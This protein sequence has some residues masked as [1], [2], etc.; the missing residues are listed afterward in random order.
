M[1]LFPITGSAALAETA[2]PADAGADAPTAML[3]LASMMLQIRMP[4]PPVA[5]LTPIT[6]P[7]C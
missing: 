1:K 5:C 7:Q 6:R 2:S 3:A 4:K